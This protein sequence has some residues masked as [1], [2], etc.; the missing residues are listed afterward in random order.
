MCIL[1]LTDLVKLSS[2]QSFLY[3][4]WFF[5]YIIEIFYC[6]GVIGVTDKYEV[7]ASIFLSAHFDYHKDLGW[8]YVVLFRMWWWFIMVP[9]LGERMKRAMAAVFASPPIIPVLPD[10]VFILYDEL[11]YDVI[12]INIIITRFRWGQIMAVARFLWLQVVDANLENITI[13]IA[14]IIITRPRPAFGRLGLG[15]WSG[16]YSSHG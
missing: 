6:H 16:G 11:W 1:L 12:I 4:F 15:G 2:N 5:W 7:W 8:A 9:T 3:S 10:L 14:I 13:M